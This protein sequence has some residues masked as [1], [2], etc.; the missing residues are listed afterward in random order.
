MKDQGDGCLADGAAG[1]G[2]LVFG[3]DD[4]G[5][6]AGSGW[7]NRDRGQVGNRCP[8][9]LRN[10]MVLDS[11]WQ[12]TETIDLIHSVIEAK[13][14]I[15]CPASEEKH[16]DGEDTRRPSVI[17]GDPFGAQAQTPLLWRRGR[18]R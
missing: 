13:P 4:R 11:W 7:W 10:G 2:T 5:R 17:P 16:K 18:A 14:N 6:R 9:E 3:N 1:A 8:I 15:A 12:C